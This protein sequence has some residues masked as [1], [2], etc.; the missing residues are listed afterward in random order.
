MDA[1]ARREQLLWKPFPR[2]Q[3]FVDAVF[4]GDYSFILYGGAIRG[5][6]TYAILGIFIILARLF[7]GSRWA[8]VRKDMPAIEKNVFPTWDKIKP[9]NFIKKH[10]L[11]TQTVTFKNGSQI[12]FFPESIKTDPDLD[13]WK[14]F[15]VNGF[16]FEEINEC[17]YKTLQKSFERAGSYII[18]PSIHNPNPIQPKPIVVASCNPT[19]NWVKD[20]IYTP[21][22]EGRLRKGWL[23]IQSKITDNIPLLEASPDYLPMLQANMNFYEYEVFVNGNWDVV[24]KTGD[25]W[26]RDFTFEK[27]RVP[28]IEYDNRMP[29]AISMDS[30]VYPYIAV[31][32]WQIADIVD[33]KDEHREWEIRQIFEIPSE[34]PDN[35]ASRAAMQIIR[36]LKDIEYI[37]SVWMYGDKSMKNRNN[38]D[39]RKR[40]FFAI[41]METLE[42]AGYTCKDK[43]L[44]SAP[45]VHAMGDFVNAIL[46]SKIKGISIKVSETCRKSIGD[47][48]ATKTDKEGNLLKIRVKHPKIPDLTYEV[49]GHLTDTMKDFVTT[50]FRKEYTDYTNR[51]NKLIPGRISSI[52]RTP[53]ITP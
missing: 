9:T 5:G 14:G 15:E 32:C 27:H 21:N 45:P 49:N 6:K 8:I 23:Y 30:N 53:R 40:S 39:D 4:S 36:W 51:R 31:T 17:Q 13:R 42:N 12:I 11:K 16:G 10:N 37:G 52:G 48:V 18:P 26:L 34:D 46:A 1:P 28:G 33:E 25:E 41:V 38:V 19:Q 3:E 50:A 7:P 44:K 47:Y 22:K 20:E 2:Q 35:T 43:I 29:V 24:V